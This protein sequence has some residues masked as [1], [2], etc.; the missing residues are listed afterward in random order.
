MNRREFV[1][2]IAGAAV[3]RGAAP[4]YKER[5]DKALSGTA[6]ERPPFSFWHHFHLNNAEA[7]AKATLDFHRKFKTDLVK[8]MSDFP[9][10]KSSAAWYELKPVAD[11]FPEQI[12]A[13]E[14]IRDGLKG[15][16]YFVETLFNPW[17]V[18]EKLS[19][20]QEVLKLMHEKPQSL[21]DALDAITQSEISHAKKALS[22]GASGVFLA[23]ANAKTGALSPADYR[24]FSAPFDRRVVQAV[25]SAKLNVLHLHEDTMR[26]DM[27]LDF[28]VA[29]INYS[30]HK[31][32]IPVA[33]VRQMSRA[34]LAAGIDETNY[35]KL[36]PAELEVQWKSAAREA[37]ARFILTPGC[38]VPDDSTDEELLRLP[39]VL[40]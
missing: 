3:L 12:R 32:G 9:Y 26:I 28:P 40:K 2:G 8:V 27:F 19:T 36:T 34:V 1:T 17:N 31:T 13:L 20:P 11:P 25:S 18:L 10:P 5:I 22:T 7:H 35:R 29:V 4:G 16:A 37:G 30:L 23:V 39:G 15:E 6:Q 33:K 21:L 14:M 38:S 24:K